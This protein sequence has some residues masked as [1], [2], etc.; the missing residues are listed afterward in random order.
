MR[1]NCKRFISMALATV[2]T[3]SLAACGGGGAPGT[4]GDGQAASGGKNIVYYTTRP[5]DGLPGLKDAFEK[6]NPGYTLEIIRGSSSDMVARLITEA[7][8]KQ[9]KAD[10]IEIN[11]LPM[12]ELAKAGILGTMPSSILD[13]LPEKAK[14]PDGSYAGTRYFGHLTPYNKDLV[15]AG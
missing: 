6:A 13:K 3:V 7:S 12:S 11:S 1:M 15:P 2:M 14:A 4:S 8:A 5:E 10:L 9:Q